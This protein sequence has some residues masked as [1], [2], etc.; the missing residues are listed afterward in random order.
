[1]GYGATDSG[2]INSETGFDKQVD[3]GTHLFLKLW[4]EAYNK[5][6][7]GFP[8][9]YTDSTNINLRIDNCGTYALYQYTPWVSSNLLFL[10]VM[11]MFW[12]G[13]QQNSINW[14]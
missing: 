10:Q 9:S 13:S 12:P 8:L 3:G 1:M 7:S 5:G 6:Q 2:D 11:K 4:N 14:N